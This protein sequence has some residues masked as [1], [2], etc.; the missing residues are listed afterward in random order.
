M[1]EQRYTMTYRL[2]LEGVLVE[3]VLP[4]TLTAAEA[5]RVRRWADVLLEASTPEVA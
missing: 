2:P 5:D 3:L 4:T 1:T